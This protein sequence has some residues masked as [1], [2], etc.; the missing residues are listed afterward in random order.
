M[1]KIISVKNALFYPF[2][3]MVQ[4]FSKI[5]CDGRHATLAHPPTRN[6]SALA[7]AVS[8]ESIR[9]LVAC[10]QTDHAIS[11]SPQSDVT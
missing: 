11:E 1:D 3:P 8:V 9:S 6:D 4:L 5:M 7:S 2:F 10:S